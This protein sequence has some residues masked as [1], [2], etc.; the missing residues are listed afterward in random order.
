MIMKRILLVFGVGLASFCFG[1]DVTETFNSTRIINSHSTEVL[2]KRQW[3]YRIEH[4]FGD[5]AG[6]NGGVQQAFGFDQAADIRM[7]MEYGFAE[8]WMAGIGRSKGI[9]L[10]YTSLLDGFI[11]GRFLTQNAEK[12]MPVSV[13]VIGN[14]FATYMK[15]VDDPQSVANFEPDF[16]RRLAYS[17]QVVVTRKFGHRLSLAIMPTYTHRNYVATNDVNGIFSVGVAAN[18]KINKSIGV[19]AEYFHNIESSGFR[20]D[21]KNSLALGFEFVTNGHNF[22]INLTNARGFGDVQYI[23]LTQSD[24]L[25]G[26][27][28]LGFSISRNFK[29]RRK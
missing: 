3:E 6:S 27:F 23:A 25:K 2:Q 8:K 24:W 29:I 7:A 4:R 21:A 9:G 15:S 12:K 10:P 14:M 5:F 18:L 28:R 20:P 16:T 19:I 13:A 17:T 11:K 1:Q 22:H 26:Q